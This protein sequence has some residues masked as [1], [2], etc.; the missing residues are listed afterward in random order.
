MAAETGSIG[1]GCLITVRRNFMTIVTHDNKYLRTAIILDL[2][3]Q[4]CNKHQ[5]RRPACANSIAGDLCAH[6]GNWKI[7]GASDASKEAQLAPLVA[8]D[9]LGKVAGRYFPKLN[10]VV[11]NVQGALILASVTNQLDVKSAF[12]TLDA[13][14]WHQPVLGCHA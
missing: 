4:F 9:A 12:P 1:A 6:R 5:R 10:G 14:K 11:L 2:I 7:V 13:T 3:E 8:I